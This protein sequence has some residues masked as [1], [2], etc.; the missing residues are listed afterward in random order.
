[1]AGP[2]DPQ[3]YYNTLTGLYSSLFGENWHLGYWLNAA[4]FAEA[5]ARLNEL[6]IAKLGVTAGDVVLDVGCGIGG[7]SCAIS[8]LTGSHVLGVTN[9]EPGVGVARDVAKRQGLDAKVQFQFSDASA[10]PFA[11]DRFDGLFSCEAIHNII[12]K[13]SL[14]RQFSRVLKPSRVMVVGDLFLLRSP[15]RLAIDADRLRSF[16]FHLFEADDWIQMLQDNN[17]RVI[18][19]INIGH[20]VGDQSLEHCVRTCSHRATS[21]P[22]GSLEQT[23]LNRTVEA[24]TLLADGFRQGDLGWGIWVAR[25]P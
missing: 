23:I 18:E 13:Q 3:N 14:A 21:A 24:T 22:P 15:D 2:F 11:D 5:G 12:D 8:Q 17:L 6:M 10:L 1:M 4:N 7:P 25:K 20:H 9:S 19:S 16:S